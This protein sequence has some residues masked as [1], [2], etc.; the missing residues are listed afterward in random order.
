MGA[1]PKIILKG[2]T[3]ILFPEREISQVTVRILLERKKVRKPKRNKV[4]S[5]ACPHSSCFR[6]HYSFSWPLFTGSFAT[7]SS[8][9]CFYAHSMI[10]IVQP[11]KRYCQE[12]T[13]LAAGVMQIK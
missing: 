2:N 5:Y 10:E 4:L 9:V 12:S 7:N 3:F 11:E 6:V 13:S 8:S 1:G